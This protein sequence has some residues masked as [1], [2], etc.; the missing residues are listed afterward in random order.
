[1]L[2]I[3]GTLG[4]AGR[5]RIVARDLDGRPLDEVLV[6]NQIT[7]AGRNLIRDQLLGVDVTPRVSWLGI[8]ADDT[9]PAAADT[10]LGDERL[11]IQLTGSHPGGTG[12]TV[13]TFYVPPGAANDVTIGELGWFAGPA[14]S[15]PDSGIL[16]ARVLY[17]RAKVASE[18]LQIERTDEFTAVI[19]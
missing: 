14:T 16:V 15:T 3:H 9:P 12:E 2:T 1:M 17:S 6:H 5:V 7:D 18:S 8:G 19:P 13:T 11:R 10:Q 4:W